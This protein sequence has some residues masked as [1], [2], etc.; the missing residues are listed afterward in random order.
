[1]FDTIVRAFRLPDLR[2]KIL[3]TLFIFAVYR[4]GAHIPVPGIDRV[5]LS[6]LFKTQGLLGFLDLFTGGAL[7]R[8]SIFA[9][10][11]TPFINAS[12]MMEL[13]TVVFPSLG[14]LKK[15]EDGRRKLTRYARN[16][17]V[18]LAAIEAL[19]LTIFMH[20]Y[21]VIPQLTPLYI[22]TTVITLTAGTTF[23]MWLGEQIS[24]YGIGNGVSLLILASILA[25]F[26]TDLTRTFI[27]L[28]RGEIG[29]FNVLVF[30]I[31]LIAIIIGVVWEE[32]AERRIPV[33]YS[34]RVVGRRVYGG[35]STYLP[36]KLN[37]AGVIPIIFA[38]TILMIPPTIGQFVNIAIV[39]NILN[40]FSPNSILYPILYFLL[41]LGFTYFYASIVFDPSDLAEN[42][43]KYGGFIPGVRPGKPT[44]EYLSNT[45]NKLN[46]VGGCFLGLIA[47]IPTFIERLTGVTEFQLGGTSI[48]IMVG[49]IL[50]TIKTLEA[51]MM[52]KSY[53]GFLK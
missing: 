51:Q 21:K 5:A 4:F 36:L 9:M 48:L 52:M 11:I 30:F 50:D 32:S 24:Q 19:G 33:Q 7:A 28:Q 34:R 20:N 42:F 26:P 40:I 37:Q 14:A 2:K 31:L 3:F 43:K 10:G 15:E 16:L 41:V 13:L 8:F 25:R 53:E 29:I 47:L 18:L 22:I 49:V 39:K 23:I 6:N 44:E 45:L 35:Q 1:V 17:T 12:I 27:L 38:I 46:F